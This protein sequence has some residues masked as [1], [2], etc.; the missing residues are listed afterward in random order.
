MKFN[1]LVLTTFASFTFLTGTANAD[2]YLSAGDSAWV[3]ND[4][5]HCEVTTKPECYVDSDCNSGERCNSVGKCVAKPLAAV[6]SRTVCSTSGSNEYYPHTLDV[7]VKMS[8]N[9]TKTHAMGITFS[10]KA[11]CNYTAN[12]ISSYSAPGVTVDRVCASTGSNEYY[13]HTLY[14]VEQAE[15][16]SMTFSSVKTFSTRALCESGK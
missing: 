14:E 6:S 13:P 16:G 7:I 15:D 9:R 3:T 11:S 8:D 10:H 12:Q 2:V 1:Q 4:R 5:V